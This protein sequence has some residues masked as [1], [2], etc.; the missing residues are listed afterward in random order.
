M[1][2]YLEYIA[3]HQ[4]DV[5]HLLL[6]KLSLVDIY[7]LCLVSQALKKGVYQKIF[8]HER[9]LASF[10]PRLPVTVIFDQTQG[11]KKI[12]ILLKQAIELQEQEIRHIH[13]T[14][15]DIT[16]LSVDFRTMLL[17]SEAPIRSFSGALKLYE[18]RETLLG[19]IVRRYSL[20]YRKADTNFSLAKFVACAKK[21]NPYLKLSYRLFYTLIQFLSIM[22]INDLF[23]GTG[24]FSTVFIVLMFFLT[25]T[26]FIT[27]AEPLVKEI[28]NSIGFNKMTPAGNLERYT[29][30]P[31]P[32]SEYH[33]SNKPRQPLLINQEQQAFLDIIDREYLD[34]QIGQP[35]ASFELGLPQQPQANLP[36][37]NKVRIAEVMPLL[38]FGPQR[39]KLVD[40]TQPDPYHPWALS[41][42]YPQ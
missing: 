2:S 38:L 16:D 14:R 40:M 1:Q 21:L 10:F 35:Y 8:A 41:K 9:F 30:K 31:K 5:L 12:H 19:N 11:A 28:K 39:H 36:Q 18:E 22:V 4:K 27:D 37:Q 26:Q 20:H 29:Y 6:S 23:I 42:L 3:E 34:G 25:L 15:S 17:I 7:H 33:F 13:S 32:V 24:T